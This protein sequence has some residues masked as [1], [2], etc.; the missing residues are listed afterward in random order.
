MLWWLLA[1]TPDAPVDLDGDTAV[2]VACDVEA[3]LAAVTEATARYVDVNEARQ[4]GYTPIGPCDDDERGAA[5]GIHYVRLQDSS[6]QVI[7]L[8]EPD[9]LL[10]VPDDDAP[11]GVRLVG[12]EYVAPALLD[13]Q[14]WWEEEEPTSGAWSDPPELFCRPF[15]GPMAGHNAFQPWHYDLHVWVHGDDNPEGVFAQYHP[16]LSCE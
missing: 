5:M 9:I 15:D 13:G 10:Y 8:L 14:L 16:E 2:P 1:C 11:D 12:I 6:D 7:E 3:D 4:A